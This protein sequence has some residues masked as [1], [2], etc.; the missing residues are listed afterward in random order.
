MG[1]YNRNIEYDQGCGAPHA[2]GELAAGDGQLRLR[3]SVRFII[4]PDANGQTDPQKLMCCAGVGGINRSSDPLI[5]QGVFGFASKG[6]SVALYNPI[7]LYM[8]SLSLGGL[9]DPTGAPIANAAVKPVRQSTD[10]SRILR[11]EVTPPASGTYTLDKCTL[12]GDP[13]LRDIPD[14]LKHHDEAICGREDHP[15]QGVVSMP[16]FLAAL[17][18]HCIL[19]T[20]LI[21]RSQRSVAH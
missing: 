15:A 16:K 6:M 19:G 8:S 9:L 10:G 7:G 2:P 18:A 3:Q 12:D 20:F 13:L 14:R 1:A 17:T 4:A 11:L 21:A 5:L